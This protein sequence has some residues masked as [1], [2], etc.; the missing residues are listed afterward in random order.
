M[1]VIAVLVW[2]D[3]SPTWLAACVAS[4][5][6][7]ADHVVAV[8]GAYQLFPKGQARSPRAQADA[9]TLA[10]DA[11]GI[12]CTLHRPETVWFGN[13][14]EKRTFAVQLASQMAEPMVDWLFVIDADE[15]VVQVEPAFR[16]YLAR[17]ERH[18]ATYGLVEYADPHALEP[19]ARLARS[20]H[21]DPV[22]RSWVR[23]IYRV[24]PGLRYESAHYV[25]TGEVDGEKVYLWGQPDEHLLEPE[26]DLHHLVV[27]EHR[28]RQRDLARADAA[29]RYYSRRDALGVE[30]LHAV[31]METPDGGL[32]EVTR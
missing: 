13:E 29:K 18:V 5:A 20:I 7:V 8:D 28:N 12:G 25:V 10:A 26:E 24:L 27:V 21:L 6:R 1:K 4:A 30:R 32:A 31:F 9:I 11:A 3:E 23:G 17:T 19:Q 14:V 22:T 16:E 2:Y 15:I